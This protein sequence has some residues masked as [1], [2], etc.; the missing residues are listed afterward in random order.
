MRPLE[1]MEPSRQTQQH[2]HYTLKATKSKT[3]TGK[4]FIFAEPTISFTL[5]VTET[6]GLL[7][8]GQSLAGVTLGTPR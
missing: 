6:F 3:Q 2:R 1:A 4:P 5:V 8:L 7:V